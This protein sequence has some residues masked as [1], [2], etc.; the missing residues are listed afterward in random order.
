MIQKW[1]RVFGEGQNHAA[2]YSTKHRGTP[3][4]NSKSY[5]GLTLTESLSAKIFMDFIRFGYD[6]KLV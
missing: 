6:V 1:T 5:S 3:D 2:L 4:F